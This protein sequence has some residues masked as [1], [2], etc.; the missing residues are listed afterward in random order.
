MNKEIMNKEIIIK[1]LQPLSRILS[2]YG[3]AV[4]DYATV[5]LTNN[6]GYTLGLSN[7]KL[8]AMHAELFPTRTNKRTKILNHLLSINDLKLCKSCDT[9][10][11]TS[12][13]YLNGS[14]YSGLNGHCKLCH[15]K[16]TASTQTS[17]QALYRANMLGSFYDKSQL[18][19]IAEFYNNCPAGYHVDHII[20]LNNDSVCGL[21]CI[22][23]LQ[24]LIA[25]D[26]VRKS[27][28]FEQVGL[29]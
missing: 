22:S 28:K 6:V 24:Y 20:P 12:E 19:E 14:N 27:N 5:L 3:I 25:S 4:D 8:S 21:H 1:L 15:S 29:N 7:N 10:K 26:N 9:I 23:N 18:I 2:K 17:R 11:T 13:Y 16:A